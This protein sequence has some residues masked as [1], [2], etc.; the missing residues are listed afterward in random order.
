[1]LSLKLSF[2]TAAVILT[3]S[4][5]ALAREKMEGVG[6][7]SV[8]GVVS[9]SADWVKDK[10]DK[11]DVS[12]KITN[13]SDKTILIF[14]GDLKCARGSVTDGTV[15]IHSDNR[16][17]DLRGKESRTVLMTCRLKSKDKG[18]FSV[19]MKVFSNPS[20]DSSTPG[21]VLAE[22]LVWKQGQSE[23]RPL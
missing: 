20:N 1:M 17:I 4:M 15:D 8:K 2:F 10:S 19:T 7:A 18:D 11:Y 14:V 13:D 12:M 21:A 9:V 16:K 3:F 23:G 6:K 22:S 5:P